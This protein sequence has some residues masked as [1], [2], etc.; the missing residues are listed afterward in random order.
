[1][2]HDDTAYG[3]G[4]APVYS[5]AKAFGIGGACDAAIGPRS[6]NRSQESVEIG[7]GIDGFRAR[8]LGSRV[9]PSTDA[10]RL[11]VSILLA[12]P[13]AMEGNV[14]SILT[15]YRDALRIRHEHPGFAGD[16]F[17]WIDAPPAS[18]PSSA[19]P[20]FAVS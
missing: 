4:G 15:L 9:K 16:A 14:G 19:A 3:D 18:S 13:P 11:R 6:C 2:A 10:D 12:Q 20:A 5:G 1:M 8:S 17:R 7:K